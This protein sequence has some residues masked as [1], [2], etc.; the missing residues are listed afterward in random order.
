MKKQSKQSNI[1]ASD[2]SAA[3]GSLVV[4]IPFR[5]SDGTLD[6]SEA[7]KFEMCDD[8]ML[9]DGWRWIKFN[10]ENH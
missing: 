10:E 6:V 8:D 3:S 5:D 1:S 9:N 7:T 2:L 4:W